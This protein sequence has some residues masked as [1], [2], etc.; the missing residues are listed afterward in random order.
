VIGWSSG[1]QSTIHK[2][3]S[4]SSLLRGGSGELFQIVF[5]GDGFVLL[6]PSEGIKVQTGGSGGAGLFSG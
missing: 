1:L 3:Q 2:S 5:A 6:Q 4:L